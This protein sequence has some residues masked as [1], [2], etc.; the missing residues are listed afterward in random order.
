MRHTIADVMINHGRLAQ[1][2]RW[3]QYVFWVWYLTWQEWDGPIAFRTARDV[4][5]ILC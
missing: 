4:A 3:A 2:P 1:W 5:R